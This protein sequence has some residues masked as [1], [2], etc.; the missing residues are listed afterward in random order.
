MGRVVA[1]LA[2]AA[3]LLPSCGG[4]DDDSATTGGRGGGS[5]KGGTSGNAGEPAMGGGGAVSS[6]D[7][8]S[9]Q[10]GEA[11]TDGGAGGAGTGDAGAG[12]GGGAALV[13][14]EASGEVTPEAGGTVTLGDTSVIVPAGAVAE[15]TMITIQQID[16]G[17]VEDLPDGFEGVGHTVALLPH[18][19]SFSEPVQIVLEHDNGSPPASPAVLRLDDEADATWEDAAW[20]VVD[21]TTM[22]FFTTRFSVLQPAHF[23]DATCFPPLVISGLYAMGGQDMYFQDNDWVELHNREARAPGNETRQGSGRRK[24]VPSPACLHWS[25]NEPRTPF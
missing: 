21:D 1:G 11:A 2:L 13:L 6:G 15:A 8:G 17:T 7:A 25:R 3:L 22:S 14:G 20:P 9:G 18:G 10:A 16:P 24:T 23:A 4:D 5:S 12:G 19:L